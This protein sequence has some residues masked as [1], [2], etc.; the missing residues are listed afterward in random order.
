MPT[1]ESKIVTIEAEISDDSKDAV[2]ELHDG[3]RKAFFPRSLVDEDEDAGTFRM[4]EWLAKDRG[5]L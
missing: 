1:I 5:F 4:P 2:V 3:S